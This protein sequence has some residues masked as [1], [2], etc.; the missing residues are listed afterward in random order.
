MTTSHAPNA[1]P[2]Q[3]PLASP[4]SRSFCAC[5][6]LA[7]TLALSACRPAASA[8]PT[9][10]QVQAEV[11]AAT[12]STFEQAYVRP[13][14][15][16]LA[17]ESLRRS[18]REGRYA[19]LCGQ[20]DAFA[21]ALTGDLRHTTHDGHIVV[22]HL[23]G[24][25]PAGEEGW[26]ADWRRRGP[27][28]N[29][30]VADAKL[31]E[32]GVGY[33][34]LTSFYPLESAAQPLGAALREVANAGALVLDLRDNGGGDDD[35]AN[36][37]MSA[38]LDDDRVLLTYRSRERVTREVRAEHVLPGPRF[39]AGRPLAILIDHRSF[40][41]SEAVAYVLQ[42]EGRAF[43]I[44]EATAG[45]AHITTGSRPLPHGF[46]L[47]VPDLAPIQPRTGVNWEGK[48]V[49][50]NAATTGLGAL[51][52]ALVWARTPA[53]GQAAPMSSLAP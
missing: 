38:L 53:G 2:L 1:R 21:R 23:G 20:D 29:W 17:A 9:P 36:A 18:A 7:S 13:E 49:T 16:T 37:L 12:A 39:G 32:G 15:A 22:E 52:R 43:V 25:G 10:C 45:G 28:V 6:S 42:A 44:G 11:L 41:A 31:L 26:V 33:L 4:A 47:D 50:P 35:T 8:S 51:D 27:S 5:L 34:K 46:S 40:S 3:S 14:G 30:G 24:S 48:G 19:Q